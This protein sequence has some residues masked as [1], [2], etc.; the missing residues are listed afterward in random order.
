MPADA[1]TRLVV[2]SPEELREMVRT[3]VAEALEG[4][5]GPLARRPRDAGLLTRAELAEALKCS[6]S[7]VDRCVARGMPAVQLLG[8]RRYR[9]DAVVAWLEAQR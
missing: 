5:V 2:T 9:L 8:D 7:S 1:S 6:V 3:A 4:R